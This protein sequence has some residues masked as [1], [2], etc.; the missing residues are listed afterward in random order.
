MFRRFGAWR[1]LVLLPLLP[2]GCAS[3]GRA[4]DPRDAQ[5]AEVSGAVRAERRGRPHGSDPAAGGEIALGDEARARGGEAGAADAEA[6]GTWRTVG[7]SVQNRPIEAVEFG[8]GAEV[9]LVLGGFH[10]DERAAAE[11]ARA[12]CHWLPRIGDRIDGRRVVLVPL[13]NPDG[14]ATHSRRNA[15]GVDL[16]RNFPTANWRAGTDRPRTHPGPAPASEPETRAVIDLVETLRP[17]KIV[18]IHDPLKVNNHDGPGAAAIARAMA[19]V[20]G[21]PVS[22]YIGYP[23]PGSFGTWAGKERGIAVVTLEVERGRLA[24][25]HNLGAVLAAVLHPAGGGSADSAAGAVRLPGRGPAEPES[26]DRAPAVER[27]E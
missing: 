23:T 24:V 14:Y 26:A 2:A 3:A 5:A 9:T 19:A 27:G 1:F 17:A 25:E 20:N 6:A 16:N 18:S 21:Y 11:L 4:S 12:L 15:R 10:G 22:G 8:S 13:V 7:R